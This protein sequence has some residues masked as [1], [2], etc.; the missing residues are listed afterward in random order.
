MV[1]QGPEKGLAEIGCSSDRGGLITSGG[2]FS[3]SN[4]MPTWQVAA[5]D[6]YFNRVTGTDK[7]PFR[8]FN[9]HGRAYPDVSA[10]GH[11]YVVAIAGNFTAVSG[12]SASSPVFAGIISVSLPL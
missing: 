11:N 1:V 8:G 2:G 9:R 7:E 4:P 5:V 3:A 10:L 12:T 6:A